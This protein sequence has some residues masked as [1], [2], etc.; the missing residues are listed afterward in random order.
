MDEF[1]TIKAIIE[2]EIDQLE[3]KLFDF[4]LIDFCFS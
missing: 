1:N 3:H 4:C 2:K